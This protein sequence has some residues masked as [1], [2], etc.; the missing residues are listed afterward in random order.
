[1]PGGNFLLAALLTIPL[2]LGVVYAFG[3][4]TAAIPRSGGD[5]VIVSRTLH[6]ALG[7]ISASCI[8]L[9]SFLSIA[10]EAVAFVTLAVVPGLITVG[11]VG[12]HHRLV[13][14]GTTVAGSN[15][16]KFGL[17]CAAIIVAGIHGG[18]GWPGARRFRIPP[19]GF[20]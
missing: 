2:A 6:P 20:P 7:T 4:M 8:T 17:G 3:F 15:N 16:W 14:W 13:S 10:F 19:P 12:H 11:L 18:P 9:S 1:F 5:Y